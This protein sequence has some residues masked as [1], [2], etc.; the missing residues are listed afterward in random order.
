MKDR[1][2]LNLKVGL[3]VLVSLT[4]FMVFVFFVGGENSFLK[5]TYL[6]RTSFSNTA[7]LAEGASVRLSGLKIGTVQEIEFPEEAE[8][9]FIKV[10]MEVNEEGMERISNDAVATIRTEGLLGDKYIEIL[11]GSKEPPKELPDELL[12]RSYT[13]PEFGQ[14]LGQS[15]ELIDNIISISK[16]LDEI[17]KSFGKQENIDNI[18]RTIA[19][20]R[21]TVEAIEKEPGV[22]NALIYGRKAKPGQPQ[23]KDF[24][25]TL[26]KLDETITNINDLIVQVKKGEGLLN[27]LLYDGRLTNKFDRTLTN[28]DSAA[29]DIRSAT[30]EIA[31]KEGII[32]ELK[33]TVINL[34][35]ISE[36]LEGGEGTLGALMNDPA[37]YDSVKNLLEESERSRFVRGA[38]KYLVDDKTKK[39]DQK[40]KEEKQ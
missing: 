31:D 26:D 8:K 27:S 39:A 19:S 14:L 2:A 7:G 11:R 29:G 32:K 24:N 30:R 35:K 15:E 6:L 10:T 33:Q 20:I 34:R 16:S 22:L 40:D 12:I 9:N 28:I 38:V 13:P 21:K 1:R 18:S 23:P 17:V 5:K 37:V 25:H 3:F 36:K 4:I